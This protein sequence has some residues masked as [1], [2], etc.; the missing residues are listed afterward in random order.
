[1][2]K[3]KLIPVLEIPHP[4]EAWDTA[5]AHPKKTW[6]TDPK[7]WEDY[8]VIVNYHSGYGH[9]KCYPEGSGRY[10][11]EQFSQEDI[12]RVV[13]LHIADTP[14]KESCALF[15]GYVLSEN[16]K[17]ILLP[18]CCG[19]LADIASWESIACSEVF[20]E[21]FCLEGHP[22][23]LARSDGTT[24][25]IECSDEDEPFDGPMPLSYRI[26]R[27]ALVNAL[28]DTK[29]LLNTLSQKLEVWGAQNGASEVANV[30]IYERE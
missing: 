28:D 2:H 16:N 23:P 17:V 6:S 25:T 9:L 27:T 11:I 13:E 19:T 20:E 30:L 10:P 3:V 26:E 24:L 22:A 18:Q 21:Y 12:S 7:G 29:L 15:G 14:L 4:V 5:G 8:L 1:M